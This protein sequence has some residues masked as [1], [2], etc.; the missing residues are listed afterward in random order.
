MNKRC[1]DKKNKYYGGRGITV[2]DEW[3]AFVNFREWAL[4]NGY[5][6]DLTIDRIDPNGNYC[7]ENCRWATI[8][9]QN[10]NTRA[11]LH[12]TLNEETHTT[13][14]WAKIANIPR[15]I[16]I[17]RLYSGWDI[18]RTLTQPKKHC[19]SKKG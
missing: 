15:H 9:E 1:R 13:A 8:F 14:E 16:I 18:K 2:C 12:L 3:Q 19:V 4:N 17:Q 5:A 10:N 7:P 11:V 6:D